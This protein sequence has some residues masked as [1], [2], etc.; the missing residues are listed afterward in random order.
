MGSLLILATSRSADSS[1]GAATNGCIGSGIKAERQGQS[2]GG[3]VLLFCDGDI[4]GK[5]DNS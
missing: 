5:L 1:T 3:I 4:R 2:M